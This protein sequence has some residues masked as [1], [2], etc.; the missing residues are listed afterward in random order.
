MLIFIFLKYLQI[1]LNLMVRWLSLE[2]FTLLY[3]KCL[4]LTTILIVKAYLY[5]VHLS[6][7]LAPM[8]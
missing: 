3:D 6:L 8:A 2:W 1:S 7:A 5:I 4:I